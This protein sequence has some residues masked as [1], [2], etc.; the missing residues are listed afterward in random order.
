[1]RFE[2]HVICV[3][4]GITLAAAH[5]SLLQTARVGVFTRFV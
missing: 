2:G 1:L 5:G 3:L 4:G